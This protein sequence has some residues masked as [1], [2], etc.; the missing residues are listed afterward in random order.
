M[1]PLTQVSRY[2]SRG[3]RYGN[4][5]LTKASLTQ[6]SLPILYNLQ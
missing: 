4:R 5:G 2:A 1:Q 6:A 3:F